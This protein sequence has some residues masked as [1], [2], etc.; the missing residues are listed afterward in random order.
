MCWNFREIIFFNFFYT[1][2]KRISR[3]ICRNDIYRTIFL[4]NIKYSAL[5]CRT[6]YQGTVI[7]TYWTYIHQSQNHLQPKGHT[8]WNILYSKKTTSLIIKTLTLYR[9]YY[10]V[11]TLK[12][13][14]TLVENIIR[15]Y[16]LNNDWLSEMT[17]KWLWAAN[18]VPNLTWN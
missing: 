9:K 11:E 3:N 16:L 7:L 12:S 15:N 6:C 4:E 8:H 14:H 18:W 13:L 5:R 17:K 1:E 2:N 10:S